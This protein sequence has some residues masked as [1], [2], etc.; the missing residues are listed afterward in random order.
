MAEMHPAQRIEEH[1]RPARRT[2]KISN[3]FR[4]FIVVPTSGRVGQWVGTVNPNYPLD[5]DPAPT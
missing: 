1:R 3:I 5:I 4:I 2:S